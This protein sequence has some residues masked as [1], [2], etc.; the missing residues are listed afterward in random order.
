MNQRDLR[1]IRI[2]WKISFDSIDTDYKKEE[3][4]FFEQLKYFRVYRGVQKNDEDMKWQFLGVTRESTYID[5]DAP[6]AD[7]LSY[8]VIAIGNDTKVI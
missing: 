4:L 6:T 3:S 8:K 1:D 7:S 2:N 5:Q